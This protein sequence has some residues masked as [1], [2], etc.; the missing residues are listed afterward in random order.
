MWWSTF[1][2]KGKTWRMCVIWWGCCAWLLVFMLVSSCALDFSPSWKFLPSPIFVAPFG[3]GSTKGMLCTLL[4]SETEYSLILSCFSYRGL[5]V[6]S[7]AVVEVL[8]MLTPPLRWSV[9]PFRR[10]SL[11]CETLLFDKLPWIPTFWILVSSGYPRRQF[12]RPFRHK[13]Q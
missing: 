7:L 6:E 12:H 13:I 5:T 3:W 4:W 11:S 2:T 10:V 8:F 9:S 1:N